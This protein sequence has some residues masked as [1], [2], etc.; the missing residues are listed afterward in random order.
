MVLVAVF[1]ILLSSEKFSYF[2]LR[3]EKIPEDPTCTVANVRETEQEQTND[4]YFSRAFR[5][6]NSFI[7]G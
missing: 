1:K 7:T 3:Y 4:G 2:S 6:K 5:F